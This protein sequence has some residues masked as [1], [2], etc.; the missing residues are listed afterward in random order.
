M[1]AAKSVIL[2]TAFILSVTAVRAQTQTPQQQQRDFETACAAGAFKSIPAMQ[3]N[4][5]MPPPPSRE[6]PDQVKG[7]T[8]EQ[9]AEMRKSEAEGMKSRD[10][11][12]QKLLNKP[13]VSAFP[14][15]VVP[16]VTPMP[17]ITPPQQTPEVS[18]TVD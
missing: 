10:E 9:I 5:P 13:P 3:A 8:P 1:N 15:P 6:E 16:A 4:C 11:E 12:V 7:L 18:W 2:G 14:A 17:A